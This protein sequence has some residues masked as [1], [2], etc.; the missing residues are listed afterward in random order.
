MGT[1]EEAR[2]YRQKRQIPEA[3][4]AYRSL[5][6]VEP[7]ERQVWDGWGYAWCLYQQKDYAQ[8]FEIVNEAE[9]VGTLPILSSLKAWCLYQ[10]YIV[11]GRE[12]ES[13]TQQILN[14]GDPYSSY[15]PALKAVL[16]CVDA[17]TQ[18]QQA[19]SCLQQLDP[20]KLSQVGESQT[21]SRGRSVN[22]PSD[23]LRYQ[24]RLSKTY[25]ALADAKACENVC[26]EVLQ[27]R[28]PAQQALWFQRRLAQSLVAQQ[29]FD[30]ARQIYSR[31]MHSQKQWFLCKELAQIEYQLGQ[32]KQA[33]ALA[34]EAAL[35]PGDSDKKINLFETLARWLAPADP[36]LSQ[37]HWELVVAIRQQAGWPVSAELQ[38][39]AQLSPDTRLSV[40]TLLQ[41]LLPHWQSLANSV[42]SHP[43]TTHRGTITKLLP[44]AHSG[45]IV[46]DQGQ[47][48]YFRAKSLA[49]TPVM[50]LAVCF[51]LQDSF[52][53]KKQRN[54]QEAVAIRIQ[55][56]SDA[57]HS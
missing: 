42:H 5:W 41:Q 49:A 28:Q 50:G 56:D 7:Q 33:L 37:Q 18:P 46:D 53:H 14:C 36:A 26:R 31:L 21:D 6:Q 45:F 8:A 12:L 54:T 16:A 48:W 19:L 47:H 34:A 9:Q 35:R 1:R 11:S 2:D 4:A 24:S 20:Q 25:L 15:S 40:K 57:A 23:W 44:N 27:Q 29:Q 30:E 38:Q 3:L 10:L 43:A 52:D 32:E 17:S 22:L 13:A 39:Q 55:E 51:C